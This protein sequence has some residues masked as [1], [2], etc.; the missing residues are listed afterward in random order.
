MI[1]TAGFYRRVFFILAVDKMD[2]VDGV[3]TMFVAVAQ[4]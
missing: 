2:D 1:D 4:R 3:D